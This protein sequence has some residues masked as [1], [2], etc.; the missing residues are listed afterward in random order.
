M[1]LQF[2]LSS[3]HQWK[4]ALFWSSQLSSLDPSPSSRLVHCQCLIR[5]GQNHRAAHRLRAW[6]LHSGSAHGCYLTASAL[7]AAGETEEALAVLDAGVDLVEAARKEAEAE[8]DPSEKVRKKQSVASIYLLKGKV[9]EGL[10]NR[11]LAA[12]AFADALNLDVCCVEAYDALVGHHML[13]AEDE[14]ALVRELPVV[15]QLQGEEE[16]S[17][18]VSFLYRLRLKKYDQATMPN[19]SHSKA[20]SKKTPLSREPGMGSDPELGTG[21]GVFVVGT[22]SLMTALCTHGSFPTVR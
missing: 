6:D 14:K 1:R 19:I 2:L 4:S 10:D 16:L 18:L 7:M 15:D 20:N 21:L 8:T 13:A 5:D 9:L 3:Q 12:E 17:D 22:E 11:D